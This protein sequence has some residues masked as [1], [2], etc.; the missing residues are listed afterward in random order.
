MPGFILGFVAG[1]PRSPRDGLDRWAALPFGA[2]AALVL[3]E[4]TLLLELEDVYW[5][6]EGVL[7]LQLSFVTTALLAS[8]ALGVRLLR[9]GEPFVLARPS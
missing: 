8:L 6:E 5:S 4:A 7:S 9:R 1:E 3:D 2:G